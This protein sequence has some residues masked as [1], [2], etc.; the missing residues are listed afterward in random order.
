VATD[1]LTQSMQAGYEERDVNTRKLLYFL[2]VIGVTLMISTLG[3][4][5]LFGHFERADLPESRVARTFEYDRPLPGPPR[6]Q[7]DPGSDI[8]D[9]LNSQRDT[10]TTYG[11]VNRARGVVRIPIDRAMQLV[12]QRGLPTRT[13]GENSATAPSAKPNTPAGGKPSSITETKP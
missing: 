12:L 5:W 6:I 7:A 13:A 9:Y 8:T 2:I 11:W 3:V 4:R 10:L 1:P